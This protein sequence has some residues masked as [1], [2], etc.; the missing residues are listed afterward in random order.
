MPQLRPDTAKYEREREKGRKKEGEP[1][2]RAPGKK[3]RWYPPASALEG[4]K[5]Q[6]PDMSGVKLC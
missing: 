1:K 6:I 2:W 4:E 3:W 5:I